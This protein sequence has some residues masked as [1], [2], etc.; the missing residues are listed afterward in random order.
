MNIRV[1][2]SQQLLWQRGHQVL[3][4]E[5]WGADSVRV[6]SNFGQIHEDVP[7]ALLAPSTTTV[8]IGK[9]DEETRL[10]NGRLN[11]KGCVIPRQFNTEITIPFMLSNR[12][13]GFLWN[14]PGVG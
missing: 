7:H 4:I 6:R 12:G 2:N 5:A 8:T 11:Q 9:N 13:Y 3:K 1:I 14:N 10:Q